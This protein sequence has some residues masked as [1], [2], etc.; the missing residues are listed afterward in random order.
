M[1]EWRT[2]EDLPA[3]EVSNTGLVRRAATEALVAGHILQNGY[4]QVGLSSKGKSVFRVVHRIV[5]VA[6]RGA[7]P[8]KME[9]NHKD[10]D[11]LNNHVD[12]LE[13]VTH[14][15]NM[16]HARTELEALGR[17]LNEADVAEI[18][19][20]L[21]AGERQR[22]LAERFGVSLSM[23]SY[24]ATNRLWVDDAFVRVDRRKK[25]TAEMVAQINQRLAN[26]EVH[27]RIAEAFNVSGST[28]DNIAN[29]KSWKLAGNPLKG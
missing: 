16:R 17:K 29:R 25:L 28:I 20:R 27:A 26:G 22:A 18:R 9:V 21:V 15:Q 3:Y 11:K 23:V 6:F 2:I 12:N 5:I 13:F 7:I 8:P 19:R 14:R 1:E 10:G 24:I 4:R